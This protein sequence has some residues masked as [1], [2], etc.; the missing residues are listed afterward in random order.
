V[1]EEDLVDAA[2][3]MAEL[4]D[5]Q[6]AVVSGVHVVSGA[7]ED[8]RIAVQLADALDRASSAARACAESMPQWK[9][10]I[11]KSSESMAAG[12]I[13]DVACVVAPSWPPDDCNAG[14]SAIS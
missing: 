7:V 13:A 4:D 6:L 14:A 8:T 5:V 1:A 9:P 3:M 11:T 2:V 10:S 12:I